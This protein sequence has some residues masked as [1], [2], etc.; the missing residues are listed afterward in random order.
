MAFPSLESAAQT[1]VHADGA[2]RVRAEIEAWFPAAERD[3]VCRRLQA[4]A[5]PIP[6]RQRA[7]VYIAVVR[8]TAGALELLDAVLADARR[9]WQGFGAG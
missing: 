5:L 8:R 3:T 6:E 1:M 7:D 2:A 9:N 4:A